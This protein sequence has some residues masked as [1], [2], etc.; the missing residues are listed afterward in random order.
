MNTIRPKFQIGGDVDAHGDHYDNN[1]EEI[2]ELP[3][4]NPVIYSRQ[5]R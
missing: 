3:Q 2:V 5:G 1:E 4:Y